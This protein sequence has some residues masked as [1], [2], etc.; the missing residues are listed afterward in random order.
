MDHDEA[1]RLTATERYLLG[2]LSPELRDQFE[3]HFFDCPECARDMRAASMFIE[4]SKTVLAEGVNK[5]VAAVPSQAGVGRFAWL[6]PSFAIP[7]LALLLAVIAYQNLVTYP[8]LEQAVNRPQVLPW[9]T[10][11]T[12]TRGSITPVIA[13]PRGGSFVLFVNIPPDPRYSRYIADL[14]N[15]AGKLE[16]SLTIPGKMAEDTLSLQI[17][18]TNRDGGT[19]ALA[20]RGISADGQ[21]TEIGRTSF[22]L[23][24]EK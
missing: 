21:T 22:E 20:L 13:A 12:R 1:I 11:N 2:E 15:P 17:P 9:A 24:V 23:Q 7:A 8:H 16:W 14:Y 10:I 5:E 3:E 19:Y 6:R 4:Q 18:G